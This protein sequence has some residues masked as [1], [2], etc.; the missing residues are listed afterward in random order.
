MPLTA[1]RAVCF[2]ANLLMCSSCVFFFFNDTAT[3][4][5]YTLSL[6]DALPITYDLAAMCGL[7]LSDIGHGGDSLP[8]HAPA[9]DH[10]VSRHVV[11]DQPKE[12]RQCA[13]DAAGVGTEKLPDRRGL[14]A[15]IASSDGT[16]G[17]GSCG[18]LG[19]GGRNLQ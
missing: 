12:R 4:E 6:H 18:G 5:I 15:Q 1:S 10:V 8:G 3:T 14:A 13:G 2:A 7:R 9:I 11:R 19:G 17:P 16:A